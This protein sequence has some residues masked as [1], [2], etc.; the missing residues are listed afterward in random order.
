MALP[1]LEAGADQ[2]MLALVLPAVATTR[3]G[4]PGTVAWGFRLNV[5][6]PYGDLSEFLP[7]PEAAAALLSVPT[8]RSTTMAVAQ[9][10]TAVDTRRARRGCRLRAPFRTTSG[11]SERGRAFAMVSLPHSPGACSPPPAWLMAYHHCV[12]AAVVTGR[13]RRIRAAEWVVCH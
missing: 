1:P 7:A 10:A 12:A 3:V 8:C 4:G 11:S 9:Q 13:G 2:V 5:V 6:S